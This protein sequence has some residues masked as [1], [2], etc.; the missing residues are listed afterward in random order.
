M[1][2]CVPIAIFP[3]TFWLQLKLGY[4]VSLFPLY[5]LSI[6]ALS[7]EFGIVGAV[8]SVM[9]AT[10][11]WLGGNIITGVVYNY[12]WTIYYNTAA[13]TAVFI[14]VAFFILMFRR[15]V[16]QHRVRMESMRAMLNVCH[17]CG[18]L[19]GSDGRWIPLSELTTTRVE[20]L[21]ECPECSRAAAAQRGGGGASGGTDSNP[22]FPSGS[23]DGGR[24][25]EV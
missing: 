4:E 1:S 17:G 24:R 16:E 23:E 6:A 2:V 19:Q 14:M 18:A 15:V 22:P 12:E 8:S 20:S 13:R 11:L 3:L 21:Q 10:A 7:W 9:L 25:T 5:M